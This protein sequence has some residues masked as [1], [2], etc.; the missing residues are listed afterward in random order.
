[1][2]SRG[3]VA[4]PEL[5]N[6]VE[7]WCLVGTRNARCTG[8]GRYLGLARM[9]K[10]PECGQRQWPEPRRG[11]ESLMALGQS[12]DQYEVQRRSVAWYRPR[13]GAN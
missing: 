9:G 10:V 3:L 11:K 12:G 7:V 2:A 6:R 8:V 1:M 13:S 5:G 4:E